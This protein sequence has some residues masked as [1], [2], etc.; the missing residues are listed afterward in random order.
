MKRLTLDLEGAVHRALKVRS[1]EL[2]VPMSELLRE[3]IDGAL[4]EPGHLDGAAAR[5]LARDAES[6]RGGAPSSQAGSPS[7]R[8]SDPA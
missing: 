2:E 6:R 5:I 7:R 3:L 4:A 1:A 8:R